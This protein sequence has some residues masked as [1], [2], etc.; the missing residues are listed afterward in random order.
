M[1][2]WAF[3][4]LIQFNFLLWHYCLSWGNIKTYAWWDIIVNKQYDII[5]PFP[6]LFLQNFIFFLLELKLNF[7]FF[8]HTVLKFKILM[9]GILYCITF[10]ACMQLLPWYIQ[11]SKFNK[12]WCFRIKILSYI[13]LDEIEWL[14]TRQFKFLK[15]SSVGITC[16]F[17]ADL[18]KKNY[19]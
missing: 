2:F 16:S 17:F 8:C 1:I 6:A 18:F 13:Y 7:N 4:F 12:K 14:V 5:S 11:G 3:A 9:E 10:K 19:F 15:M